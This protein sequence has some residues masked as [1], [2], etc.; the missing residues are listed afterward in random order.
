MISFKTLRNNREKRIVV[1]HTYNLDQAE[2]HMMFFRGTHG[3]KYT[4]GHMQR[5]R[6]LSDERPVVTKAFNTKDLFQRWTWDKRSKS[7]RLF[8]QRHFALSFKLKQ[9]RYGSP[10]SI[11]LYKNELTQHHAWKGGK[12]HTEVNKYTAFCLGYAA[13][14][15]N[16]PV[17][18]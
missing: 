10:A 17:T 1:P 9:R 18:W 8:H 7:L 4:I 12:I 13:V 14:H 15:P 11:R 16:A 3:P 2:G 5:I 6:K